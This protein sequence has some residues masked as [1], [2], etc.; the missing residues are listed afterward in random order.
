ML[1]I[2]LQPQKSPRKPLQVRG[3][4]K[5]LREPAAAQHPQKYAPGKAGTTVRVLRVRQTVHVAGSPN[6]PRARPHRRSTV[7]LHRVWR[8]VLDLAAVSAP[9]TEAFAATA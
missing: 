5:V 7:P 4:R 8:I 6:G 1:P 3:V 9:R 2:V